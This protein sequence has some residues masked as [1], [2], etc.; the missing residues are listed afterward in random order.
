MAPQPLELCSSLPPCCSA[1]VTMRG[2]P[3]TSHPAFANTAEPSA[4]LYIVITAV[5]HNALMEKP[6]LIFYM[7]ELH[8]PARKLLQLR[9]GC[10]R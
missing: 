3:G 4:F 6:V 7:S 10:R 1:V 2:F 9:P 8:I 5:V